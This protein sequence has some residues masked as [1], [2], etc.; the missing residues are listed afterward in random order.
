MAHEF[1]QAVNGKPAAGN[2]TIEEPIWK[3]IR[4]VFAGISPKWNGKDG[5]QLRPLHR[6]LIVFAAVASCIWFFDVI[7]RL[8]VPLAICYGVYY[9]IWASAIRPSMRRNAGGISPPPAP[10]KLAESTAP[11][12][13]QTIAWPA[14]STVPPTK[15]AAAKNG[16]AA[17]RRR[18]NWRDAALRDIAAKPLRD[19]LSELLGSM[20][21]AALVATVAACIGPMVLGSQPG[22]ERFAMY[23]W[24]ATIGTLGSWAILVPAKLTEGKLEDQVPMRVT[25]LAAG[26]TVGVAAWLLGESLLLKSPGWHDPIDAGRG[27]ISQEMLEWPRTIESVNPS[28]PVYVA[29]FGFLFLLPRWWRQAEFTRPARISVWWVIVSVFWAWVLHLFWWFPQPTGLMAAGVIA[30]ATQLSSPWMP[31]S[32]RRALSEMSEQTV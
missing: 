22:S 15:P 7:I 4:D 1:G 24:L 27:L 13:Q 28:L 31:P 9:M 17:R 26:A 18:P 11:V 10:V 32:R 20:I 6:A 2:D 3:A 12:D 25:L 5:Q 23:F 29:Y 21:V 19:K 8:A 16:R 14:P 30:T